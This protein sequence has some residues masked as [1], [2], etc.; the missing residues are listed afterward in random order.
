MIKFSALVD[1]SIVPELE[2]FLVENTIME[3]TTEH[4]PEEDLY[5][6]CGYFEDQSHGEEVFSDLKKKFSGIGAYEKEEL[7]EVDWAEEY[8]KYCKPWKFS[9]FN[10]VPVWMR[11]EFRAPIGTTS[12]YIDSSNAFGTG[13]HESTRLCAK[14]LDLF[15]VMYKRDAA[16]CI[17][18][19]IDI[20]CGTGI[21]GISAIKLGLQSTVFID[22]DKQA[23]KVCQE[24]VENNDINPDQVEYIPDDLR[25]GLLGKQGDLVFAN[26]FADVLI[27]NADIITRSVKSGGLLC[28]SGILVKE[29]DEVRQA[30]KQVMG[31]LWNSSI[32]NDARMGEWGA[33]MFSKG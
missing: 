18:K 5:M 33:L 27:E 4:L 1:Q 21:L 7:Q 12:I 9:R 30:F 29:M 20:G 10:W 13:M 15:L 8:K 24:N 11:D 22:N 14:A 6:L 28:L 17:K 16:F 26:I 25:V 19:C 31:R 23:I 3:C 2:N 32:E